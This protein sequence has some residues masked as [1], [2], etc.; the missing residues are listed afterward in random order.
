MLSFA[1]FRILVY[2]YFHRGF[3]VSDVDRIVGKKFA[4]G[5]I[6]QLY[7]KNLISVRYIAESRN[8]LLLLITQDGRGF[9]QRSLVGALVTAVSLSLAV[10]ALI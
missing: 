5:C 10:L 4:Q 8:G 9:L 2:A 3:G 7:N 1:S 6:N